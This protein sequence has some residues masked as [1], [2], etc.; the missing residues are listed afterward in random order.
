MVKIKIIQKEQEIEGKISKG[1]VKP[2]GNSAH[3]PFRK[4]H[5]GKYV[6]VVVPNEPIFCWVFSDSELKRFVK[7]AKKTINKTS[8]KMTFHY[9]S[10]VE[11]IEE[12]K[13]EVNDILIICNR[14]EED[15][16]CLDLVKKI[17]KVYK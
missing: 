10:A 14:L 3:I 11:R 4:E 5:M 6:N 1:V 2:F 17:R 12:N 7:E 9:L 16:K 15:K 13:F 8:S